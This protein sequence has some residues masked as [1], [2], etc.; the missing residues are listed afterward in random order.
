MQERMKFVVDYIFSRLS[1]YEISKARI[2]KM[3]YLVDWKYCL[4]HDSQFTE[5]QWIFHLYGPF[6]DD[7]L[8]YLVNDKRYNVYN[9]HQNLTL[10]TPISYIEKPSCPVYKNSDIED[11]IDFIIDN[12]IDMP[13]DEFLDLVYSTY[14]IQVCERFDTLDLERLASEYKNIVPK[15]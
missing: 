13:Y 8:N 10:V 4:E 1:N 15:L 7:P 3:I 14:P 9:P 11:I 5:I 6:V 2:V 12:T